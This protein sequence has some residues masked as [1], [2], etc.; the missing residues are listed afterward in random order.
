MPLTPRHPTEP[1]SAAQL[2]VELEQH[3]TRLACFAD[4]QAGA[5]A[6]EYRLFC[7]K[8]QEWQ[9]ALARERTLF[10]TAQEKTP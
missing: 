3:L 9:A 4:W 2:E 7:R 6:Q 1:L 8:E 5:A 10:E